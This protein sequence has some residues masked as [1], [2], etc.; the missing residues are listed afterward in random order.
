MSVCTHTLNKYMCF[1]SMLP[2]STRSIQKSGIDSD[3]ETADPQKW[4]KSQGGGD[5]GYGKDTEQKAHTLR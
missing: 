4:V 2:R 1:S 3:T 5:Q